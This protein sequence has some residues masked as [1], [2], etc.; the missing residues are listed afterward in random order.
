MKHNRIITFIAV[1]FLG[2]SAV[3]A[4][5]ATAK[6]S[7]DNGIQAEKQGDNIAAL[8]CYLQA[9][10]A[11]KSLTEAWE[12][13]DSALVALAAMPVPTAARSLMKLRQDWDKLLLT[14]ATLIASNPPKYELRYFNDIAL[15]DMEEHN[16]KTN[17]VTLSVSAPYFR[18]T[19]GLENKKIKEDFL[20]VL[21][22][23]SE[24]KK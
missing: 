11:D 17:T 3:F 12:H 19:H 16:Y 1:A 22:G 8:T 24:S 15:Q 9:L 7:L 6:Q 13:M 23:I 21:H 10:T 5:N 14:A 18:Q 4:Q 2:M 20:N